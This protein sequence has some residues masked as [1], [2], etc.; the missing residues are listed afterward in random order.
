MLIKFLKTP[1]L[2]ALTKNIASCQHMDHF[3]L[4]IYGHC[5]VYVGFIP[6]PF[7]P[8]DLKIAYAGILIYFPLK[9]SSDSNWP[10]FRK[11]WEPWAKPGSFSMNC[12]FLCIF[13][14]WTFFL[15]TVS[16]CLLPSMLL[17]LRGRE[18]RESQRPELLHACTLWITSFLCVEI[19][20]V[21]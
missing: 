16:S 7:S 1:E 14:M 3:W 4:V 19:N 12:S 5:M 13:K 17:L 20:L 10:N 21:R 18:N 9:Q 6:P 8:T 11:A 15:W 2:F